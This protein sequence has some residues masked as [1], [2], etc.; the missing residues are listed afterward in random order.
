MK[1][2]RRKPRHDETMPNIETLMGEP[3]VAAPLE[4]IDGVGEAVTE[5]VGAIYPGDVPDE[6]VARYRTAF[7]M[8]VG[9]RG[10]LQRMPPDTFAS[11]QSIARFGYLTRQVEV[12]QFG[13]FD[14]DH[15][16]FPELLTQVLGEATDSDDPVSEVCVH[17]A[18]KEPDQPRHDEPSLLW[19]IPGVGGQLRSQL[20]AHA[21]TSLTPEK[22]L[23]GGVTFTE[24]N[25]C[26]RFGFFHRCC[27]EVLH[28]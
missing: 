8:I 27:E 12:E 26:W 5:A 2:F 19:L 18:L 20:S 13:P 6:E 7:F 3:L 22:G 9:D 1:L 24:L 10:R 17:W 15:R 11:A 28:P 16:G 23:P 25:R 14:H 4:E 21:V